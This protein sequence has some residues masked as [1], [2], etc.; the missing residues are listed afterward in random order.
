MSNNWLLLG[1]FFTSL[2][3]MTYKAY[4][5]ITQNSEEFDEHFLILKR[6]EEQFRHGHLQNVPFPTYLE[7][8]GPRNSFSVAESREENLCESIQMQ[9]KKDWNGLLYRI[10]KFI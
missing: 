3:Y 2:T 7:L 8:A 1:G 6:M 5:K 10:S 4:E 9:F